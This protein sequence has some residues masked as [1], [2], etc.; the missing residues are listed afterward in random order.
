MVADIIRRLALMA[1]LQ[2][3]SG[4][5]GLSYAVRAWSLVRVPPGAPSYHSTQD[6]RLLQLR[7]QSYVDHEY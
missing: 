7:I 4:L 1:P 3:E 2:V 5:G 6:T